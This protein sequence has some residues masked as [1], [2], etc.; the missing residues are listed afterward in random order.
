MGQSAAKATLEMVE[1]HIREAEA[2]IVR[3]REIIAELQRDGCP[4]VAA[5]SLLDVFRQ[6]LASHEAHAD[7]LRRQL[8]LKL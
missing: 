6:T 1:Q 8:Q 2:H 7:L 3:Q 5:E 4:T